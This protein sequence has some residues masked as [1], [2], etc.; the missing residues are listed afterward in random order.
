MNLL[1]P[2]YKK[3]LTIEAWRRYTLDLGFYI[4]GVVVIATTLLL[5]SFFFLQ[6]QIGNLQNNLAAIEKSD[7]YKKIA[8]TEREID[9]INTS[10]A[11]FT[12][13]HNAGPQVSQLFDELFAYTK[14]TNIIFTSIAYTRSASGTS[15]VIVGRAA[16]RDGLRSFIDTLGKNKYVKNVVSPVTNLLE[17]EQS[18][19]TITINFK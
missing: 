14:D 8:I 2:E 19:F 6:F 11:L 15:M 5:P 18:Q 7:G 4:A 13:F 10:L 3:E 9:R 16:T 12:R 1:P 17:R